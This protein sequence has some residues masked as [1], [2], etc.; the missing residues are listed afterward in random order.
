VR[1]G[2][3]ECL[4]SLTIRSTWHVVRSERTE[5]G[6]LY[7]VCRKWSTV[8]LACFMLSAVGTDLDVKFRLLI[9]AAAPTK[10][11]CKVRRY[12]A[13]VK[14]A[15]HCP[16]ATL[17]DISKEERENRKYREKRKIGENKRMNTLFFYIRI[18]NL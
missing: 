17:S 10:M 18:H 8:P 6:Q 12:T 1:V 16:A 2:T 13:P 3:A 5:D 4:C 11:T 14:M 7:C 15:V 9:P